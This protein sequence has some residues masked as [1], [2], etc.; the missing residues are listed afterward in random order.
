[1]VPDSVGMASDCL[2]STSDA[3]VDPSCV[4]II[5]P[6]GISNTSHE[7]LFVVYRNIPASAIEEAIVAVELPT[8]A[9][10]LIMCG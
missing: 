8:N 5:A 7:K 9:S 1:M 2:L 3:A 10:C 4:D 6:G